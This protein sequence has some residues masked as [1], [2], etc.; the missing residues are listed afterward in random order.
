MAGIYIHIPFCKQ[1]C[2][3]CD[4]H[5]STSQQNKLELVDSICKEIELRKDYLPSEKIE[6]IYF[7]G[8]TPS[9]CNEKELVKI[10]D[11]ISRNFLVSSASEITLEA[12]PDDLSGSNLKILKAIG[13]NR[14]S[15]GIQSFD[16]QVLKFLN[17]AHNS[18][19]SLQCLDQSRS[20]GFTNISVDLIFSIPGQSR[21]QLK[22]NILSTLKFSPEHISAYSLTIEEKTVFGNWNKKGKLIA[23]SDDEAAVQMEMMMDMLDASGYEQYEISN[24]CKPGFQSRHN[25][26][27]WQQ[28]NYL[29]IGPS[30]HSYDGA[31]RQHNVNNNSLYIRSILQ[32]KIPYEREILTKANQINEY[33]LT[34]LRTNLGCSNRYLIDHFGFNLFKEKENALAN[35][36]SLQMIEQKK[37]HLFLT[38]KGKLMADKIAADLFEE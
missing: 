7:G 4:F 24:F 29:G 11:S 26:S 17:R 37:D 23:N 27:Y 32:N 18:L 6:T 12:N 20:C 13:I 15:I 19:D 38:R 25:S 9:L 31:S 1:A 28:K 3:Y 16:D 36:I 10:L 2:H 14:L 33:L 5:F 34:S 35:F 22:K 8:G 21:E 30:A